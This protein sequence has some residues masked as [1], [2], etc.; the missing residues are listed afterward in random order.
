MPGAASPMNTVPT[1][2]AGVPPSG[3]AMPVMARPQA[4]PERSQMPRTMASAH[5][6]LTAPCVLRI[7][8]DTPS[9]SCF[10][11]FE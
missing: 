6:W 10:A 11:R 4:A 8:S 3:P 9:S 2:L 5:A 7:S 1:G